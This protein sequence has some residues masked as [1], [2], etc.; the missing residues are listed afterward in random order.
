MKLLGWLPPSVS[1]F[2]YTVLL[3]PRPLRAT[4]Q[5]MIKR[6][7]PESLEIEGVRLVL[8]PD[9]AV[10]SGA[11]ALG[12]YER[13]ELQVFKRLLR[14]GMCVL[15]VGA[16]IGLFSTVAA[17]SVGPEGRVVAIEPDA[18]NCGF[19][20]QSIERNRFTNLTVVQCALSN[21]TGTGELFLCPDNKADHR[22]YG[23]GA[24]TTREAVPIPLTTMDALVR[25]QGLPRVD[26]IK[27]DIQGAEA[28]AFEGMGEVLRSNPD[29]VILM[30]F[31]PWGLS[32]AGSD[33]GALLR[34]IRRWGFGVSDLDG[35]HGQVVPVP[36]DGVLLRRNL[37]RHHNDLLL[38]RNP[39]KET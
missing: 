36:D 13:L 7:I 33:P 39:Q 32:Q 23:A 26:V 37:E 21:R 30:E 12:C 24:R 20:R 16:N 11:L 19:L 28:L 1:E 8:N 10:L 34:G 17:A 38:R 15:D 2:T 6:L 29:I 25:E 14:P 35:D 18:T 27:M 31:W 4:A 3:R 5:A 22:I 9:D